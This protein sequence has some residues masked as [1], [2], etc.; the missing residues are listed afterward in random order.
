MRAVEPE[1]TKT[2]NAIVELCTH[3]QNSVRAEIHALTDR[4]R[5]LD[6]QMRSADVLT[7]KT[8]KTTKA[9]AERFEAEGASLKNGKAVNR[10][11][12][13]TESTHALL[14]SMVST[15]LLIDEMLPP[16][17][18]LSPFTSAH[19]NHYPN[20]H[21]LL[22]QKSVDLGIDL[23]SQPRLLQSSK[24]NGK[25]NSIHLSLPSTSTAL[26]DN[27]NDNTLYT[28]RRRRI[29]SASLLHHNT[30]PGYGTSPLAPQLQLQT[31][32]PE[33]AAAVLTTSSHGSPGLTNYSLGIS[34]GTRFHPPAESSTSSSSSA[35]IG[36]APITLSS[37][38][39]GT[40]LDVVDASSASHRRRSSVWTLHN[41]SPRPNTPGG[42]FPIDEEPLSSE[43]HNSNSNS[44]S[45]I[46]SYFP[47]QPATPMTATSV[48]PRRMSWRRSGSW[49][50]GLGG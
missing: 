18:R 30:N 44:N 40:V 11:A 25:R 41:A 6:E 26:D 3:F 5:E 16:Q 12:I 8:L 50:S 9:R 31:I 38:S 32:L 24:G 43:T 7:I 49:N 33:T 29:S 45:N 23:S 20:L 19:K 10:L 42:V 48:Q 46:G 17:D 1:V 35:H 22:A 21:R 13:A 14:T 4:Q 27:T 2:T 37:T 39:P 36:L 47:T 28:R 15:L 34:P